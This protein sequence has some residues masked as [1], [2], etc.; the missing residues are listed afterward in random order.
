MTA[1]NDHENVDPAKISLAGNHGPEAENGAAFIG[2]LDVRPFFF[3]FQ[4]N[5]CH[6]LP[7][8]CLQPGMSL[9][10]VWLRIL[11]E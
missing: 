5:C 7:G 10:F 4:L 3:D 1:T 9:Y 11:S 6:F 8:E 2:I